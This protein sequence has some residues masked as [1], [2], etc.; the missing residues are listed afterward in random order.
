MIGLGGLIY[1]LVGGPLGAFLF[2]IGLLGILSQGMR[3]YTGMAGDEIS[4]NLEKVLIGNI[5]G[6]GIIASLT[7][8]SFP[9]VSPDLSGR[10]NPGEVFL[11]AIF[12]GILM[13]IAVRAYRKG[14][15]WLP[16]IC[17]MAFILA[18]F[19]HSIAD[20]YYYILSKDPYWSS[21]FF[22]ILGNLIGCNIPYKKWVKVD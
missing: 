1:L 19:S 22:S 16:I 2:S 17:V 11:K 7:W 4:W 6:T 10:L 20:S 21:W 3:L 9:D 8:F 5:I 13:S 12:C 18:G 15:L 14:I